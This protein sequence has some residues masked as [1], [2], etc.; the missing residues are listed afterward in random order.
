MK[1]ASTLLLIMLPILALSAFWL[2]RSPTPMESSSETAQ[3]EQVPSLTP[4]EQV[5]PDAQA[6]AADPLSA[7][8]N[9]FGD[10]LPQSPIPE[11][12]EHDANAIAWSKVDMDSLKA[13]MP[14][15]LYWVLAAPT[16][17]E[18]VLAERK[19]IKAYWD[20]QYAKINSNQ[21]S[22][23][24]IRAY[25]KHREQVATDYV[26]FA[27][28]LLNRYGNVLPEEAYSFQVF[29]R[30]LNVVVLQELPKKLNNALESRKRFIE[31]RESWLADK[32]AYEAKLAQEREAALRELG[33]I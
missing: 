29:A 27:T 11:G 24:E 9:Q 16:K 3:S 8:Q 15:N 17:D 1:R 12:Y 13:D 6:Q 31:E 25:F 5:E 32:A 14:N 21:A 18:V 22:E 28:S 23:D 10:N 7:A 20:A 19:E 30:N 33:K 26:E 2:A 4:I